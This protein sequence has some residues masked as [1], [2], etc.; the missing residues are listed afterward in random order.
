M[1]L[2][3]LDGD[4]G[5]LGWCDEGLRVHGSDARARSACACRH[6]RCAQADA[7]GAA[8]NG[9]QPAQHIN[10]V[11]ETAEYHRAAVGFIK[12]PCRAIAQRGA[13]RT[14]NYCC[15]RRRLRLTPRRVRFIEDR[16]GGAPNC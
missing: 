7:D 15:M 13:D 16:W 4:R 6:T 9:P 2:L 10:D 3:K 1:R 12:L 14:P 5:V 8:E 11:R